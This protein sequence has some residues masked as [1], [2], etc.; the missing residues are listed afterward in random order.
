MQVGERQMLFE[1]L[2]HLKLD[3]AVGKRNRNRN[4]VYKAAGK[5]FY[6]LANGGLL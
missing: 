6:P 4:E 5:P 2:S 1:A 3:D